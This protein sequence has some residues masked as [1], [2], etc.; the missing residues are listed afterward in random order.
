MFFATIAVYYIETDNTEMATDHIYVYLH[1]LWAVNCEVCVC[2][3]FYKV[4]WELLNYHA[5]YN[6]LVR[7]VA[8][9]YEKCCSKMFYLC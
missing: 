5:W 4:D 8:L 1:R 9:R 7:V 6:G 3:Q 2:V